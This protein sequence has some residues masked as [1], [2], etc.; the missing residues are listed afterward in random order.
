[1]SASSIW[2]PGAD[3]SASLDS[4][5]RAAVGRQA[6]S[7]Q[8]W[9]QSSEDRLAAGTPALA[10]RMRTHVG[11]GILTLLMLRHVKS[12]STRDCGGQVPDLIRVSPALRARQTIAIAASIGQWKTTAK[13]DEGLYGDAE[14]LIDYIRRTAESVPILMALLDKSPPGQR[15]RRGSQTTHRSAC[16]THQCSSWIL[17]STAGRTWSAMDQSFGWSH[18]A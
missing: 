5:S 10:A 2:A 12:D 18:H 17:T 16:I 9:H 1:M 7:R 14:G 6:R 8:T 4:K 13:V 3:S 15:P 11:Y